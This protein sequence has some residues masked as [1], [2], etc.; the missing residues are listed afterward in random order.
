VKWWPWRRREEPANT[1]RSISDPALAEWLGVGQPNYA[2]VQVGEGSAFG[3]SAFYRAGVIISS[4]VAGLPLRTLR[5]VE[6]TRTR[7]SSFIDNPGGPLGPTAFEWKEQAVLHV[8]AHGD[9]FAEHVFNGAGSVAAL[10]LIHPLA[11]KVEWAD[12]PGGK[13][14]TANLDLPNGGTVRKTYDATTMTQV[15]GPSLDGLRGMSVI[16]VARNSLGTAIAGDRAAAKLFSDGALISGILTPDEDVDDDEAKAIKEGLN[17]NVAGWEN[18]SSIAVINRR[19]KFTPWTM[20]ME[21]A[22]F[23]QSRQ[24]S[25]EEVSRW[26]GVPPHLLMQTEKQTSWGTGV[27]EQNRGLSRYTLSSY[28]SRFEERLSRLLPAPRF[29]EF[30]FAGLLQPAPEQ[31][32]PLLIAQVEA[33]L[34]TPNEYRRIRGLDPIAGGDVLRGQ[35]APAQEDEREREPA[36]A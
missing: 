21:D 12:V 25:V 19:M 8:F 10:R 31:E 5:E 3:L 11:V 36:A 35:S 20:S 26:T 9:A 34:M 24:F 13:L 18:A 16:S 14:Y 23:L 33:G 22:Q 2:G 15:M 1:L 17:R 30:D 7:V 29:C 27:A 32:I 28:T 4:Q 6:G